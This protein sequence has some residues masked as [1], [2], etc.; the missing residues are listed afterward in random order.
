MLLVKSAD[1][2]DYTD[3]LDDHEMLAY[4]ADP[5]IKNKEGMTAA[6]YA[7]KQ[8]LYDVAELLRDREG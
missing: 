6:D 1:C 7:S 4:G 5:S 2:A 3:A 8:E